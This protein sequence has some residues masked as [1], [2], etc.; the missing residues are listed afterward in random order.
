MRNCVPERDY[1]YTLWGNILLIDRVLE[2]H[3]GQAGGESD[4]P[5][6]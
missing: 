1:P 2:Y 3:H 5:G 4:L 6:N